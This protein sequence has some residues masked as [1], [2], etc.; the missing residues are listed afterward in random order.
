MGRQKEKTVIYH[1]ET[2]ASRENNLANTLISDF[3][4]PKR[5]GKKFLWFEQASLQCCAAAAQAAN[6]DFSKDA[7]DGSAGPP[8]VKNLC[9]MSHNA[10]ILG[11][12]G[13]ERHGLPAHLLLEV[14]LIPAAKS[15]LALWVSAF[16]W[17][18]RMLAKI[19]PYSH[20]DCEVKGN[21]SSWSFLP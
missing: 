13:E 12:Q 10:A 19:T 2:E 21:A 7:A 1:P 14:L 9:L 15:G 6:T 18:I 11:E 5:C 3:Q 8:Q 4:P 16:R 17:K 20:S